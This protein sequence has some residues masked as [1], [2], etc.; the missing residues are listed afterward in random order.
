MAVAP[1]L[2]AISVVGWELWQDCVSGHE[3]STT[4]QTDPLKLSGLTIQPNMMVLHG[5]K[6]LQ[7]LQKGFGYGRSGLTK[8]SSYKTKTLLPQKQDLWKF[9]VFN[10]LEFK[11]TL[12]NMHKLFFQ[13]KWCTDTLRAQHKLKST[14]YDVSPWSQNVWAGTFCTDFY[15][16]WM[17][18]KHQT[19]W[20][21]HLQKHKSGRSK[22]NQRFLCAN[23]TFWHFLNAEVE[24]FSEE[25]QN[26]LN[27]AIWL[28]AGDLCFTALLK[29]HPNLE[30]LS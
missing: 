16:S 6:P 12:T 7:A 18:G 24:R 28:F 14:A 13:W 9:I 3:L 5:D 1:R 11:L 21:R 15:S 23:I 26:D 30:K 8:L 10:W 27:L 17:F 29:M 4:S 19:K 25:N 2:R 20:L 22:I